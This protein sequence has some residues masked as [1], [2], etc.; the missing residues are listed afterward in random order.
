L[1]RRRQAAAGQTNTTEEC[2]PMD[3][4]NLDLDHRFP[5]AAQTV[6]VEFHSLCHTYRS[7]KQKH[8]LIKSFWLN[9]AKSKVYDKTWLQWLEFGIS[10]E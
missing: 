6:A 8:I 1:A 4:I 7:F 2:R 9:P 5:V 3:A 10:V